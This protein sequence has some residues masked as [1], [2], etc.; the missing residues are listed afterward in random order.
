MKKLL[1]LW[2][3]MAPSAWASTYY[4]SQTGS[5]STCS[6]ALP[7]TVAGAIALPLVAGDT[8]YLLDGVYTG[9][10]SMIAVNGLIGT[11][12]AKITIQAQN[13]GA[14]RINGE[15]ARTPISLRN[16]KYVVVQG[17]NA[18]SSGD[19][20]VVLIQWD[21]PTIDDGYNEIKRVVAWNAGDA[22]N[23]HV[24]DIYD[25]HHNLWEDCGGFGTGRKI[26]GA[27][28]A[29]Y[30]T[31]RRLWGRWNNYD[32][33]QPK[34]GIDICYETYY[35]LYENCIMEW[36]EIG[37]TDN[38]YGIFSSAGGFP[39]S[40][41]K[42][43]HLR[44]LASIGLHLTVL[45]ATEQY[46]VFY[47]AGTML[48]GT[49][50]ANNVA[51]IED[52]S[53]SVSP[54]RLYDAVAG[55]ASTADHLTSIYGTGGTVSAFYDNWTNTNMLEQTTV[56]AYNM[57]TNTGAGATI[58]YRTVDGVTGTTPLWPWSMNDRISAAFVAAGR[59][60]Y[61]VDTTIQSKFGTY[62]SEAGTSN[63]GSRIRVRRPE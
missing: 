14:V 3:L 29:N 60:P 13:D 22:N 24:F 26:F 35:S 42:N 10:N 21:E 44:V 30:T 12:G 36:D 17:V 34:Q 62:P 28:G 11:S 61:S 45:N 23:H 40:A 15:G 53:S 43:G 46:G 57:Y 4:A 51:F 32:D 56:G 2:L 7:C 59:S 47:Q 50:Y 58:R 54:F 38:H 27:Y 37:G 20:S 16:T 1:L 6:L 5:G 18:H 63:T 52:S 25:S 19:G 8:L 31:G 48:T 9:A 55:G 49:T 39:Y 33:N 41:D